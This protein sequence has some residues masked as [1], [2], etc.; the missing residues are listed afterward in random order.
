VGVAVFW[1]GSSELGEATDGTYV[2]VGY[3]PGLS[4][5]PPLTSHQSL[6]T[7][8]RTSRDSSSLQSPALLARLGCV[9]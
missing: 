8:H 4:N 5:T 7:S 9:H 1:G 6:L 3:A 2:E